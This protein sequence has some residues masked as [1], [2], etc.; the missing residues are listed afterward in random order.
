MSNLRYFDLETNRELE[1]SHR[2]K[3]KI[4]LLKTSPRKMR[5][6]GDEGKPGT[7]LRWIEDTRRA[8]LK[9]LNGGTVP[10]K[11]SIFEET[12]VSWVMT[13]VKENSKNYTDKI[14]WCRTVTEINCMERKSLKN[15]K[16]MRKEESG[17]G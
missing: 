16:F 9:V 12:T 7:P 8:N 15:F 17:D 5:M 1:Q 2:K 4:P 13:N 6:N 14:R 11:I 3:K 10:A